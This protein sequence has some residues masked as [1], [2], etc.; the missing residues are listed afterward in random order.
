LVKNHHTLQPQVYNVPE[1]LDQLVA[2][3]KLQTLGLKIDSL[4]PE[5]KKYLAAWQ[6]GT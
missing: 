1:E 3:L 5:Q 2:K 6:E 4:S